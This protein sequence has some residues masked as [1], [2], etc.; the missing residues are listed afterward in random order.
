MYVVIGGELKE[1]EI[2]IYTLCKTVISFSIQDGDNVDKILN[3][4][5][6]DFIYFKNKDYLKSILIAFL[7][8]NTRF[9]KIMNQNL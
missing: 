5:N 7:K 8:P 6:S 3:E 2:I 9:T 4:L 1:N